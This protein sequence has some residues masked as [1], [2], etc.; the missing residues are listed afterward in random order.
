[1]ADQKINISITEI[2]VSTGKLASIEL[3][4]DDKKVTIPVP[5]EIRAD[6]NNQFSRPN[7]TPLQRKKY[8]TLMALMRAAYKAGQ[9]SS[10]K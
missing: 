4:I 3:H 5:S 10:G 1:M 9:A 7:P 8:G 6:F 2:T